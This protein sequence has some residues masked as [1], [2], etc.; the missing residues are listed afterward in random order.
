MNIEE[1]IEQYLKDAPKPPAPND[2]IEKLQADVSAGDIKTQ[3][4]A[5]RRWFAP[6]GDSIS[7]WRV[8]TAAAVTIAVLIPL[9]YGAAK[10]VEKFMTE[11]F[12]VTYTYDYDE[13]DGKKEVMAYLFR[14]TVKGP[15]INSEE[16]AKQAEKEIL[17][18]IKE[19]K[20]EQ[21][22]PGEYRAVLSNG[23]EVIYDTLEIPIEILESENREE[24]IKEMCN[25]IEELR[26][27]GKFERIF[28]DVVKSPRGRDV[29]IYKTRYTLSNG[30]TIILNSGFGHPVEEKTK[31]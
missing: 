26:K 12:M 8:A 19:G 6:S 22:S 17:K 2:L 30:V 23:E 27:A 10:I 9:S 16:D 25:G 5:F 24:K 31:D 18:L 7:P 29:Y 4:S 11:E 15:S 1:K 14:P 28:L 3:R 21:I 13:T 20:V